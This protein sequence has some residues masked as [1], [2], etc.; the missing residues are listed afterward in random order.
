MKTFREIHNDIDNEWYKFKVICC[1]IN[2]VVKKNG[3]L[4]MGAGIAKWFCDKFDGLDEIWGERVSNGQKHLLVTRWD[5]G[6]Y[7]RYL[8]AFP[9]KIHWQ[10]KSSI[11]LIDS[12]LQQLRFISD[13]MGWTRILLPRPGCNNGGL[14]WKSLIKPL[15]ELYLD[16]R[17]VII[18]KT[19]EQIKKE[20]LLQGL[21]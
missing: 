13:I 21:K 20:K 19:I 15:C 18:S 9:T 16:D 1:T 17:F 4:V 5:K 2:F 10:N 7:P 8:V 11:E 12:S 3:R 14:D 6:V